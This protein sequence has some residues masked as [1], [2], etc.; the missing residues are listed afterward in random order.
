MAGKFVLKT[1]KTGKVHFNLKASNGQ[2]VLTSEKYESRRSAV[3]GIESV[4]KNAATDARFEQE[5][6]GRLGLLRVESI[7]R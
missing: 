7:E 1:A 2:I 5:R 3:K 6:Q 4:K